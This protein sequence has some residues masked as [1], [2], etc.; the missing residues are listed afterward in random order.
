MTHAGA[1][2]NIG[3][4]S[5]GRGACE[6]NLLRAAKCLD[7]LSQFNAKEH[8]FSVNMSKVSAYGFSMGGSLTAM[9][10]GDVRTREKLF[11]GAIAG[12][13]ER[14]TG[15]TKE[16][17]QGIKAPFLILHGNHDST[18]GGSQTPEGQ[19]SHRAEMMIE[20]L[21]GTTI[22]FQSGGPPGGN[23]ASGRN[24]GMDFDKTYDW[25][26]RPLSELYER[27]PEVYELVSK[28]TNDKFRLVIYD[29]G[30]HTTINTSLGL[31]ASDGMYLIPA[32]KDW[33][34]RTGFLDSIDK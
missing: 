4:P 23:A 34:L 15:V 2:D 8:G 33:V 13:G 16:M 7:V 6:A 32:F 21:G 22:R 9:L 14:S 18:D 31:T 19:R 1:P 29:T 26:K 12:A 25:K 10:L 24:K 17:V 11:M 27:H 30:Q 20:T 5:G 3:E 28:G